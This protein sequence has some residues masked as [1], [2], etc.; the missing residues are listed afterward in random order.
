M[1]NYAFVRYVSLN[2][3]AVNRCIA[4]YNGFF[5]NYLTCEADGFFVVRVIP[6][7]VPRLIEYLR[8]L[9]FIIN[10]WTISGMQT[11]IYL[12]GFVA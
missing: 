12:Q 11:Y 3:D 8:N 5:V 6:E 2:K 10:Q 9:G 7:F 4:S 1:S